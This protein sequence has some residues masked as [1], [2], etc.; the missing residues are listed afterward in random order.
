MLGRI[1]FFM[2]VRV[3][4]VEFSHNKHIALDRLAGI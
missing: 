2:H 4:M 3:G 1:L